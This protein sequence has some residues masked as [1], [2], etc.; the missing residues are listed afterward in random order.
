MCFGL[1][2]SPTPQIVLSYILTPMTPVESSDFTLLPDLSIPSCSS[3]GPLPYQDLQ[4]YVLRH[5]S[6]NSRVVM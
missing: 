5:G 4:L 3:R 1:Y 2:L 6:S